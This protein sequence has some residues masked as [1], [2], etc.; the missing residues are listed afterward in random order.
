MSLYYYLGRLL[1]KTPTNT[2][3]IFFRGNGRMCR[4]SGQVPERH[5][6]STVNRDIYEMLSYAKISKHRLHICTRCYDTICKM[7]EES[8]RAKAQNGSPRRA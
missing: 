5:I 4:K 2:Q 3:H 8:K 1:T 6:C 7:V